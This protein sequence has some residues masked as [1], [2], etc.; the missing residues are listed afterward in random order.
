MRSRLLTLS[1]LF[2]TAGG[3]LA[4]EPGPGAP[5]YERRDQRVT[6]DD[7]LVLRAADRLLGDE[8]R[9]NRHDTRVCPRAAR[10]W[11]LFCALEAASLE[12]LG[13]YDHRRAALQEVRFVIDDL[14]ED[15]AKL[16]GHRLMGFNNLP[17]TRFADIKRVLKT[18][19]E[20]VAAKLARGERR[21][22][23]TR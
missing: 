7:L 6:K 16:G 13:E 23:R 19:A 15:K 4:S 8:S 21:P 18:A 11:S 12:V 9:W 14:I 5:A 3:V 22:G 1:L 17:T 2:L 10:T 20:A